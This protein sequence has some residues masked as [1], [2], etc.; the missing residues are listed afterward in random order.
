MQ[1]NRLLGAGL[2]IGLAAAG[3][4]SMFAA[5]AASAIVGSFAAA[6]VEKETRI[7]ALSVAVRRAAGER[8]VAREKCQAARGA[9]RDECNAAANAAARRAIRERAR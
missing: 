6:Q 4:A 2:V 3:V 1:S 9:Q 8:R 5:G 7:A